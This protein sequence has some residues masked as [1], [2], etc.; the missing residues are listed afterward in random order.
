MEPL[1]WTV[2]MGS[3]FVLSAGICIV[4]EIIDAAW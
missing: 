3:L 1:Y 4:E 2:M